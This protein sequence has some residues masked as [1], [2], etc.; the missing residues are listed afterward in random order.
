[1][2]FSLTTEHEQLRQ[3][4]MEFA[5]EKLSVNSIDRQFERDNWQR[6]A[7][8][9][10]QGMPLPSLYSNDEAKDILTSVI[11]MEGLGY[12]CVDNGLLFALNA[13]IW[14]V[15]MPLLEHGNTQL[16]DR[17]LKKMANGELI[18]AQAMT[19]PDAGSD[20][21][22]LK[23][24]A[25]RHSEGYVITGSKC[26]ISL[27][28]I[29]DVFL[30]FATTNPDAGRWG[31]SAFYVDADTAG[32]TISTP[33]KKMGLDTVPMA[34]LRFNECWVPESSRLGPEGAGVGI[35][36]SALEYERCC[37]M[38]GQVGRMQQQLE[39]SVE[40]ARTRRQSGQTIGKFQSVSNRIADMKLRLELSRLMLYKTAWI[41]QQGGS[42]V[43]ECAMLKL[44]LSE[45]FLASGMDA[46]RV[47]GG[48]G[49]LSETGIEKDVRDAMGGV[50]YGGTSDIQRNIIAGMLGL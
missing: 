47:H 26:M 17:Y 30:V 28:P 12:G 42:A 37:I 45:M 27:A 20:V 35:A 10:V 2:D 48:Y 7:D 40:Y 46:M 22:S 8:E 49:Y 29:A 4:M 34:S 15:Q 39:Q 33:T 13:H 38:A 31:V 43:M 18:A 23:T 6:C 1:M 14:T 3:K 21:F 16:K 44:H 32:L 50:L 36:T 5:H 9:G 11:A 25:I 24:Q 19:E 41:K